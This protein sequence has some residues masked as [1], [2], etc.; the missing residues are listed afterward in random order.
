M[1]TLTLTRRRSLINGIAVKIDVYVD[2]AKV[3]TIANGGRLEVTLP[4]IRSHVLRL[5]P[6]PGVSKAE[7]PYNI[8]E[9]YDAVGEIYLPVSAFA[10]KW[11]C[12]LT[13]SPSTA[14]AVRF[15]NAEEELTQAFALSWLK[16]GYG[17]GGLVRRHM[18]DQGYHIVRVDFEVQLDRLH[19]L[20][21]TSSGLK[22]PMDE[23][24]ADMVDGA[25]P[26]TLPNASDRL[27]IQRAVLQQLAQEEPSLRV[28]GNSI[29]L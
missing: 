20:V 1:A 23:L 25:A 3:G 8:P 10:P 12:N 21:H 28:T 19:T 5:Q 14:Q 6:V 13:T 4:D 22:A 24:Y 17:P 27:R 11:K 15:K 16:N 26:F 2:G 29:F 7:G 18:A 9:G